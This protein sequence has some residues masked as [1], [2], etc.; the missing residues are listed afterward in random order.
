MLH[1]NILM[2]K[3]A[4]IALLRKDVMAYETGLDTNIPHLLT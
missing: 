1:G 3:D 4:H 2:E